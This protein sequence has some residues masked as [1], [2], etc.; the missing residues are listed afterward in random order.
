MIRD[1]S[2]VAFDT[3]VMV[4]VQECVYYESYN[5]LV[6][7]WLGVLKQCKI[8]QGRELRFL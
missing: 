5:S 4:K 7:F 1:T 6:T 2:A 3:I 8:Q